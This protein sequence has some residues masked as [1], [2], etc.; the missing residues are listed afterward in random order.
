[1]LNARVL[2]HDD[3][4]L[5]RHI[6]GVLHHG[7]IHV[8]RNGLS[9]GS[10]GGWRRHAGIGTRGRHRPA[11]GIGGGIVGRGGIAGSGHI[12][13]R[14]GVALGLRL[15]V[16]LGRGVAL[17]LGLGIALWIHPLC[18]PPGRRSNRLPV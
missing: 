14:L 8:D 13:L 5:R 1:M 7:G 10:I 2:H 3:R 16:C 17:G 6:V 12:W 18:I 4:L 9:I 11:V 15:G